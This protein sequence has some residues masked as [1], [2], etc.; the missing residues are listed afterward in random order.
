MKIIELESDGDPVQIV[1][2]KNG[3]GIAHHEPS[4][5][6]GDK[7]ERKLLGIEPHRARLLHRHGVG[8]QQDETTLG[9]VEGPGGLVDD[10]E[11]EGER[12]AYY[13]VDDV[14]V[15]VAPPGRALSPRPKESV[16]PPPKVRVADHAGTA[17][18]ELPRVEPEVGKSI[19]LDLR[20]EGSRA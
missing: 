12:G 13:F 19:V 6:E 10:D 18:V 20:K 9:E 5:P 4:E 14:N 17:Q 1:I 15:R 3:R 7:A 8:A 2:T 16:P 11:P